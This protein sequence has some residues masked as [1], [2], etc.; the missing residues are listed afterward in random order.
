MNKLIIPLLFIAC[1][2]M[3]ACSKDDEPKYIDA[4]DIEGEWYLTNIKGWEY[5]KDS[6]NG[7]YEFNETFNYN[8]QGT[9]IGDNYDDA[10]KIQVSEDSCDL[11]AGIHYL[12][13]KNYY[14]N[15]YNQEWTLNETG[16]IKFIGNQLINGT[17]KVSIIK[18][19]DST[20][21]TY[22]KDD[23]GETYITYTRL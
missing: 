5:D 4:A 12:T 7:K 9:P 6:P 2:L 15:Y 21:T 16:Y 14:W 23:D 22:Q 10:Q 13:V 19:T 3:T 20:M 17:M 18:I 8:W 1:I 11:D